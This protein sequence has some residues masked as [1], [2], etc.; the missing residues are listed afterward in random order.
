[1]KDLQICKIMNES[2]RVDVS[3]VRR[4]LMSIRTIR[5]STHFIFEITAVIFN[6]RSSGGW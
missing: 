1:M 4:L 6:G 2:T 5:A 3:P